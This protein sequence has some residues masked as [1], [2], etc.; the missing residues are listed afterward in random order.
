MAHPR[1]PPP[2]DLLRQRPLPRPRPLEARAAHRILLHPL[3]GPRAK[4][5][6]SYADSSRHTFG[7]GAAYHFGDLFGV[8]L[9]LSLAAQ[10]HGLEPRTEKKASAA[11][12]FAEYHVD[13][14]IIRGSLALEGSLK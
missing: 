14:Q 4:G 10:F 2:H 8:D 13:G 11:L 7:L 12:P 9:S 3:T 1:A 5:F 6:T